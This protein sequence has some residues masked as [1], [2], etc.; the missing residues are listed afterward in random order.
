MVRAKQ[1][2][3]GFVVK[4]FA[5][6]CRGRKTDPNTA[7]KLMCMITTTANKI[8]PGRTILLCH[9]EIATRLMN[10]HRQSLHEPRTKSPSRRYE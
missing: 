8:R 3:S 9:T 6:G 2:H 1:G 4:F 10:A 5:A 7:C